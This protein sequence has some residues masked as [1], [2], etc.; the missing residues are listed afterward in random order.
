MYSITIKFAYSQQGSVYRNFFTLYGAALLS[1]NTLM[2]WLDNL[3]KG[4][5]PP[6]FPDNTKQQHQSSKVWK[7]S[8]F[9]SL[10]VKYGN[11]HETPTQCPWNN[12]FFINNIICNEPFW[13]RK[14]G[15]SYHKWETR[16]VCH[17]H[18]AQLQ[19]VLCIL[20]MIRSDILHPLLILAIQQESV[21]MERSQLC[22]VTCLQSLSCDENGGWYWRGIKFNFWQPKYNWQTEIMYEMIKDIQYTDSFYISLLDTHTLM[23]FV[24][25]ITLKSNCLT[26]TKCTI[27]TRKNTAHELT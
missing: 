25:I 18:Q 2:Y 17:L 10:F 16:R 7:L 20:R 13:W 8:P 23:L 5:T 22:T 26:K 4:Q 11:F 6:V 12:V 3:R 27:Q 24:E 19:P 21:E 9:P 1:I 15:E 14:K